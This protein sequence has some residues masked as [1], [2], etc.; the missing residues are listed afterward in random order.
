MMV[1]SLSLLVVGW[2][3][4]GCFELELEKLFDDLNRQQQRGLSQLGLIVTLKHK[5]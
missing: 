1:N 2:I 4:L 5:A 3:G